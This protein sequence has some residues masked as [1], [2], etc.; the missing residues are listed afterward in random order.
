MKQLAATIASMSQPDIIEFE[1][2]GTITFEIDGQQAT[3]EASDVEIIS[4]D[5]PGWLVANEGNLTVALDITVTALEVTVTEELRR[6]GIARELV[7]R[8]Q[9]IRKTSGFDITDK[10]D[11][12]IAS[13]GE[14]DLVVE[15]YRDYMS[16][17]VLANTF[18]ILDVL[19]GEAVTELD[20]DTFK[21]NIRIV[22]SLK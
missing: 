5:I 16:R 18:E 14:T 11:V 22:K 3:I 4:E 10:I 6:E 13:N 2:N 1:K 7:N 19:S 8:I 20:F 15:E 12:Y 21:V 9:N 17:Q